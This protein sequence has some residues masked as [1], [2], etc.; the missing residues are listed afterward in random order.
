MNKNSKIYVA[1]HSGLVGSA[2]VRKLQEN[3]YNNLILKSHVELDLTRQAEVERFFENERPEYV[4]LAA[5]KVGGI[6]INNR[7]PAEFIY[8]NIQIQSN[9]IHCAHLFGVKK[10]LF[11][12][13]SCIYPKYASQPIVED[14]LLTGKLEETN[15]AYAIA[16]ISG[17]EMCK[18][19]MRE[20][21]DCFISCM[22]SNIYG[23]NDNFDLET[24]HSMSAFIRKLYE[25]KINNAP[26]V[27]FWGSGKVSREYMYVDDMADACLFLMETY[28]DERH[29]NIGTGED[30]ELTKLINIINKY[31]GYSGDVRWDISRPDGH[32]RKL[33]DVSKL[34]KLGWQHQYTLEEGIEMTY[35][36]FLKNTNRK[37]LRGND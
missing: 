33:T 32:P 29:I 28:E 3:G 30:I 18:F 36:W 25:A 16:K 35:S 24:S 34:K 27:E 37:E 8:E 14:A 31:V 6:N 7:K 10:L 22:P 23:I 5:A 1:G 26:Y 9:V 11:L 2:I 17:L 21:G 15:E 19:Y 4:F 20:Y 12:G 13:S